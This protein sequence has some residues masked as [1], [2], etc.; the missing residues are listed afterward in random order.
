MLMWMNQTEIDQSG[1]KYG[2]INIINAVELEIK[3]FQDNK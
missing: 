3:Y 1:K 2:A